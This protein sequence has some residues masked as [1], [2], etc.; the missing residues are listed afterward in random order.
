LAKFGSHERLVLRSFSSR[1]AAGPRSGREHHAPTAA[2]ASMKPS[3]CLRHNGAAACNRRSR[4]LPASA[5]C[6]STANG[7]GQEIGGCELQEPDDF[8]L[9]IGNSVAIDFAADDGA[10]IATPASSK[11]R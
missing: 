2:P 1:R 10:L 5:R 3:P 8:D 4:P 7:S 9:E 6:G 11:I